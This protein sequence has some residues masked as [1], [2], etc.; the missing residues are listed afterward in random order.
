MGTSKKELIAFANLNNDERL[1]KVEELES[2]IEYQ[3]LNIQNYEKE[4]QKLRKDYLQPIN[5]L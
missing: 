1:Q 2:K 5:S 3:N 4:I